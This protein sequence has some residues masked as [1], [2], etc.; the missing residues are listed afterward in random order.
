M[1][2]DEKPLCSF[3]HNGRCSYNEKVPTIKVSAL[4]AATKVITWSI[5]GYSKHVPN[6]RQQVKSFKRSFWQIGLHI[7]VK[8]SYRSND[9]NADIVISFR[10]NDPYFNGRSSALAYA[11]VGTTSQKVDIVFNDKSFFWAINTDLGNNQYKIEPVA[12][13]EILHVLGLPHSPNCLL[14]VMF[15]SYHSTHIMQEGDWLPLQDIWGIRDTWSMYGQY[16]S[17]YLNRLI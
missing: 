1:H 14:C 16:L 11:Y 7:P 6:H 8:F 15:P 10:D 2:T 3:E 17:G 13:H 12:V 5:I 4:A 9:T